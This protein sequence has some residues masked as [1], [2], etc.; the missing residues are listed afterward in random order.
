MTGQDLLAYLGIIRK[1][2]WVIAVLMAVTVGTMLAVFITAKP[3][4]SAAVRF[5]VTAPPSGDVS[6]YQGFRATT[7]REEIA[8]TRANFIEVLR[9]SIIAWE[10]VESEGVAMRGSELLKRMEIE[11][12]E[13]S[14]FVQLTVTAETAGEA[15]MLA[16]GLVENAVRYYSDLQAQP[17]TDSLNFI[18]AQLETAQREW[19]A[20]EQRLMQFQIENHMGDLDSEIM[21]LQALIRSLRLE[22]DQAEA[23]GDKSKASAYDRLIA[24]REIEMQGLLQLSTEYTTLRGAVQRSKALYNLLLDKQAEAGLTENEV[25]NSGFVQIVEP[26]RKPSRPDSPFNVKLIVAGA[27]ASLIVGVLLTFVLEY[28]GRLRAFVPTEEV[29]VEFSS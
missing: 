22:R 11:E 19:E 1:R 25:R 8:W 20:A 9:S 4:Y 13:G 28:V 27:V 15:Q 6:L 26:A 7:R 12:A 23:V 29:P 16:N 17:A 10:T 5:M 3:V 21:S 2:L 14:D 24:G 18:T